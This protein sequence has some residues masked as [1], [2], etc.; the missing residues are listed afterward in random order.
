VADGDDIVIAGQS[1]SPG[2]R[3]RIKV[4]FGKR[5]G[6]NE[7]GLPIEVVRGRRGG[8]CLFVCA[9]VHG[10]EIGGVEIIR[11]VLAQKNLR[12]LRGTLIA[13]PVV[14]LYGF[15]GLSR[16]LPDRR[17]LNR[18]FPGSPGGSLASR[19][20][21]LFLEQIVSLCSHG[22]DY[23]TGAGHRANLPHLRADLEDPE[24]RRLAEAFAAP[25][26]FDAVRIKGSLRAAAYRRK[27]P[28]LV[29]EGGEPLEFA[30]EVISEGVEGT[31]RVMAAL[32]MIADAPPPRH[33]RALA[34]AA[35]WVRAGRSGILHLETE[36][37][38]TVAK[39]EVLGWIS[40]PFS[41]RRRSV[42]AP[43]T[44]MICAATTTPLVYQGD[45]ILRLAKVV[46]EAYEPQARR[47]ADVTQEVDA[48][49]T[50]VEAR[51]RARKKGR[52]PRRA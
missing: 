19:L 11:R 30:P 38:R 36:L 24:V 3:R 42:R 35:R 12:R 50:D 27:I 47:K 6:G 4:P 46:G 10:D 41:S 52:R 25:L 7:I 2:E 51:P 26:L 1:I 14:N 22:I 34:T 13:V 8:K 23:H 17:D 40:D 43:F 29:F 5:V 49:A 16:Y 28:I 37:G 45:A 39:G 21:H 33:P 20:A 48:P 32:G 9:A 44:G 18:S 15:V 31:L